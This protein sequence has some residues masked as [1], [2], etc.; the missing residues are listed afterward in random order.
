MNQGVNLKYGNEKNRDGQK[1]LS[2]FCS[3]KSEQQK[4]RRKEQYPYDD[5]KLKGFPE[6][7]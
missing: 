2:A 7:L 5:A 1:R 6:H 4:R 3:K